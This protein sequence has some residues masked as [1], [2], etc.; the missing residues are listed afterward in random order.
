MSSL[1]LVVS[2][3][4]HP[5]SRFLPNDNVPDTSQYTTDYLVHTQDYHLYPD[6]LMYSTDFSNDLIMT[7]QQGG[8]ATVRIVNGDTYINDAKIISTDLLVYNG[9]TH[10]LDR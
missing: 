5:L 6:Y 8:N 2:F 7:S 10:I 1:V 4:D 9:V 3:A